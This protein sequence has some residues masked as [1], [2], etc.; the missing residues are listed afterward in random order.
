M[1]DG[2]GFNGDIDQN[3]VPLSLTSDVLRS[4]KSNLDDLLLRGEEEAGISPVL[5]PGDWE[6]GIGK[7]RYLSAEEL[8]TFFQNK[9]VSLSISPVYPGQDT[10][11]LS[12]DF[13][14]SANVRVYRVAFYL[15]GLRSKT[16]IPQSEDRQPVFMSTITH[17]GSEV[18]VST[19]GEGNYFEHDRLDVKHS[20]RVAVDGS[21][22]VLEN[23][24]FVRLSPD[25]KDTLFGAP[26]PFTVWEVDSRDAEWDKLDI[27]EVDSGY[28]Q[29]CGTNYAFKSG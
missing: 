19:K 1:Y 14:S 4:L 23:G 15:Q 8:Q 26:G 16:D 3:D 6:T 20:F 22:K 5:F 29:F 12:T 21:K 11:T 17:S 2:S 25:G 28:L 18:I 13:R 7:R 24:E 27:S 9:S 10:D